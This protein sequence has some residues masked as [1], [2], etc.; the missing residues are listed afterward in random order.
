MLS[1]KKILVI[2][3]EA[4]IR[5]VIELKLKNKG[6]DVI[7]AR[8]GEEGLKLIKEEKPEVVITDINMPKLNGKDLCH[9]TDSLKK[10][11]PFLT[12]VI[13]ARISFDDADWAN[14]MTKT[15]FMEKPFSPSRIVDCIDQYFEETD[16]YGIKDI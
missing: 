6:Y 10:S 7:T 8:D 15:V 14:K 13:T 3:D 11:Q 16:N 4:P 2:D 12:I 1:K 5:R 9:L